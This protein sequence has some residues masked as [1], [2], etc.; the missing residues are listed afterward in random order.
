MGGFGEKREGE[1]VII[2]SK[3]R[4]EIINKFLP[5]AYDTGYQV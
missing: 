1:N 4:Q 5:T 3:K 2:S